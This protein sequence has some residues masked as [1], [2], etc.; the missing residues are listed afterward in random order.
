VIEK[1]GH[2]VSTWNI[3]EYFN[4]KY[5]Q[6]TVDDE[7]LNNFLDAG[8]NRDQMCLFNYFEPNIMPPSVTY[9]KNHFSNLNNLTAAINLILP[10]QYMPYHRDLYHRWKHIHKH[11]DLKS[12]VRIIVMLE[13]SEV[14]Q[15][16]QIDSDTIANWKAGDW[17]SWSGS[18]YHAI[19]NLS[20]RKRYAIQ[21]TGSYESR[22]N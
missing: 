18:T 20:T 7:C 1:T 19:Y 17:F 2:I 9:V 8:H 12:I 22:T 3:A 14:G 4:L 6:D 11:T 21:L 16:L 5:N 13:D 10:G 15:I